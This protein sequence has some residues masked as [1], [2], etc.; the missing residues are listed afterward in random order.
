MVAAWNGRTSPTLEISRLMRHRSNRPMRILVVCDTV[1]A[2]QHI[3]FAQPLADDIHEGRV[4]LTMVGHDPAWSDPDACQALWDAHSADVL[5][6]S[7]YTSGLAA[8]VV[9]AARSGHAPVIFHIDDDLLHVP[10]SLGKSKF[11]HY[12]AP[13]RLKALRDAMEDSDMVY[14]STQPLAQAL[15]ASGI[16]TPV[17]AGDIYCSM[18]SGRLLTNLPA[19]APVIGYM[20]TGGHGADMDIVVPAIRR[21]LGE[22]PDLRFETFGTI[23]AAGALAEFGNRVGHHRGVPD[24]A[25]FLERLAELGWWVGIAPLQDTPFNRCKADTKW[26]EYTY[27]GLATVASNLPVYHRACHGGAGLLAT[28]EDDWYHALRALVLNRTLRS[29]VCATARKHLSEDYSRDALKRQL[30]AIVSEAEHRA[31]VKQMTA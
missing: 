26:V 28:T 17:V 23:G 3:S 13:D 29:S 6:L 11:E 22:I 20:A 21:L 24:Y 5:I 10:E 31:S 25:R 14:A 30:L 7:R 16:A 9:A 19:T 12:N 4:E 2:T 1:G 8:G 18:D 15:R 27:A